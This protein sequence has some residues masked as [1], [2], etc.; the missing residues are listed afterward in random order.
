[1]L[2]EVVTGKAYRV[3]IE[4]DDGTKA[5][6]RISFWG[7]AQDV[8]FNDGENLEEKFAGFITPLELS[9]PTGA[10][11]TEPTVVNDTEY[12]TYT[13]QC[14]RVS[15]KY[16]RGVFY[17]EGLLPTEDEEK[18]FVK[19]AY[20]VADMGYDTVTFYAKEIPSGTIHV[21]LYECT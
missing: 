10:W 14:N 15:T 2:E 20:A 11:S 18:D 16:P 8:E 19:V 5:W 4:K 17:G 7:K 6:R 9:I 12:Y 3:L 13:Y 1:M 21:A